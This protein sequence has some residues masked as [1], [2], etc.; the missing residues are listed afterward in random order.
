[1]NA[2]VSRASIPAE[3]SKNV[4]IYRPY[5]IADD[6]EREV[7]AAVGKHPVDV[8]PQRLDV[9]DFL[10]STE[11]AVERKRGD[12]L[13]SSIKD[14]RFR[15]ELTR[16]TETFEKPVLVVEDLGRAFLA[17]NFNPASVYGALGSAA[18]RFGIPVIPTRHAEDTALLLYRLA[19]REQVE[20]KNAPEA[21]P[22]PKKLSPEE[23][24]TYFLEGF[25]HTGP[26][27]AKQ[28]LDYFGSPGAVIDALRSAEVTT[29]KAGK[30]KLGSTAFDALK[31][32][33]IKWV[34][35]NQAVLGNSTGADGA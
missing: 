10:C 22:A 16:L 28:L 23:R 6:R 3:E 5:I 34:A 7:I 21:R 30:P 13:V 1:M 35:D 31:G 24:K 19:V 17:G 11:C 20:R 15:D 26:E 2:Q 27:K 8:I 33:G 25:L 32:F 4:L 12:D 9:A 14:G 18:L 29:T